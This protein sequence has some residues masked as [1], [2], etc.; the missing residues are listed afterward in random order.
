MNQPEMDLYKLFQFNNVDSYVN[1]A[2]GLS[3]DNIVDKFEVE[4]K[5]DKLN[6]NKTVNNKSYLKHGYYSCSYLLLT[7]NNE[8]EITLPVESKKR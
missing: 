3:E 7:S 6:L 5:F 8:I 2:F 4:F 1:L